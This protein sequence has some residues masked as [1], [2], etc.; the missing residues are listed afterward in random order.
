MPFASADLFT[1]AMIVTTLLI[2]ALAVIAAILGY[3]S[4][5]RSRI[6]PE[7]QER[8]RRSALVA[9][10]KM[11]DATV[12]EIRG[13]LLFYSYAVRGVAYTASQDL[14]ALQAHLPA[15]LTAVVGP[16]L[17]KYDARNPA[18]SIILAEE[19]SGLRAGQPR[20]VAEDFSASATPSPDAMPPKS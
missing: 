16:V 19:W 9:L 17:V 12:L 7:A 2:V 1:T 13:D 15:D 3:R 6:P 8:Q 14:S 4:W 5:Q 11:G 18:N 20:A 10:G